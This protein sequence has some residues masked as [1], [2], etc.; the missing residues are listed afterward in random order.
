MLREYGVDL[1]ELEEGILS[2]TPS[3]E[4]ASRDVPLFV[5]GRT[6]PEVP[7]SQRTIF[8]LVPLRVVRGPQVRGWLKE[9]FERQDIRIL[10]D[11]AR[12]ALP[13]EGNADMIS[14][15]GGGARRLRRTDQQ[16]AVELRPFVR[17]RASVARASSSDGVSHSSSAASTPSNAS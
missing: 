13:L 16:P 1:R 11:P 5:S 12:N 7:A 10:E 17:C 8:Q 6:L 2:F 14:P 4:N 3:Q 15:V 9:A